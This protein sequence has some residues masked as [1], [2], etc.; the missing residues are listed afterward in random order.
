MVTFTIILFILAGLPQT[1]RLLK[2]KSSKDIS[3][4]TYAFTWLAILCV[5]TEAGGSVFWSNLVSFIILSVNFFLIL[6]YRLE[7]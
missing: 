5:L 1:F 7:S 6:F 2:T 4:S 3:I